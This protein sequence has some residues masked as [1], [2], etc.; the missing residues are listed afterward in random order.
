[1]SS[2]REQIEAMKAGLLLLLAGALQ[3]GEID[4]TVWYDSK[5]KVA[6][7]EGP[8]SKER[9]REPFVPHWVAYEKRRDRALRGDFRRRSRGS[10]AYPVWGETYAV[11]GW[12]SFR[13]VRSEGFRCG[14]PFGGRLRMIIR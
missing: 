14:R 9:A 1:M 10:D 3:A 12:F 5:G 8:A 13:G 4:G 7:V 2:L 6:W 11:A